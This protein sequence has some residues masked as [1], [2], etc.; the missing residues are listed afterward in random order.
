MALNL[1]TLADM[2]AALRG[3]PQP[4]G[5]SRLQEAKAE[6]KLAVVDEKAFR[7]EVWTRDKSRCRKC[8]RKVVKAITRIPERGEIHHLHGR[9]GDLRFEAKAALLLCL[10]DHEL[11]TGKVNERWVTQ[12]TKTWTLRNG[13]VVTDARAKVKFVRAA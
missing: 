5:A 12:A 6:K 11:V 2:D 13:E 1:P 7:A 3:K 8:G 10:T 9:L 4:K